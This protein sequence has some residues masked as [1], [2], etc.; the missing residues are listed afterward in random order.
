MSQALLPRQ[1][2]EIKAMEAA[3]Q[4]LTEGIERLQKQKEKGLTDEQMRKQ[5]ASGDSYST[6]GT[7]TNLR[8]LLHQKMEEYKSRVGDTSRLANESTSLFQSA[9]AADR[10]AVLASVPSLVGNFFGGVTLGRA[11]PH[12][13]TGNYGMAAWKGATGVPAAARDLILSLAGNKPSAKAWI[14]R[15]LNTALPLIGNMAAKMLEIERM[16]D[17]GRI[18]GVFPDEMSLAEQDRVAAATGL[19]HG[20]SPVLGPGEQQDEVRRRISQTLAR[21]KLGRF[22]AH[23]APEIVNSMEKETN[24]QAMTNGYDA[25]RRLFA[26]GYN[27]MDARSQSGVPG[28]DDFTNPKNVITAKE[29]DASAGWN[30][31][32]VAML[33]QMFERNGDLE[34][35]L[36]SYWKRRKAAGPDADVP[37]FENDG[38]LAE[39]LVHLSAISNL[40]L[41]ST[42]P[43]A[44]RGGGQLATTL[45]SLFSFMGWTS[46]AFGEISNAMGVVERDSRGATIG[47]AAVSGVLIL[48]LL[49]LT[50]MGAAEAR[51]VAYE[52]VNARPAP[53]PGLGTLARDPSLRTLGKVAGSSLAMN[54]PIVG[55]AI[56]DALGAPT[57]KQSITEFSSFSRPISVALNLAQGGSRVLKTG[58][59]AEFAHGA[60]QSLLPIGS[61][62]FNRLPGVD[63]RQAVADA[64]RVGRVAAG[65]LET[66][67]P[68]GGGLGAEPTR[69]SSLVKRAVARELAGDKE[70]ADALL[71]EAE[72]VKAEQSPG[73]NVRAAVRSS[74]ASKTP[75]RSAFGRK[76]SADEE[77]G[78][79]GRMSESQRQIYMRAKG[80]VKGLLERTKAPAKVKSGGGGGV[81]SRGR[82]SAAAGPVSA[83]AASKQRFQQR[84]PNLGS[85][86]R[87]TPLLGG[88]SSRARPIYGRGGTR[89]GSGGGSGSRLD[90]LIAADAALR[91]R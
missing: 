74:I 24:R 17:I 1:I 40:P 76:L 29:A 75:D 31:D 87:K 80:G 9:A 25:L 44:M 50:G 2:Q 88:T 26:S 64:A 3:I 63:A 42:R 15:N 78:L 19:V 30:P 12:L 90:R 81:A 84:Y 59:V 72:M 65:P 13:A 85:R 7:L 45:Q 34:R 27:L 49:M 16:T 91:Q 35:L 86:T 55:P 62:V 66:R 82:R 52:L 22:I 60:A 71:A 57:M 67:A 54:L 41:G 47:A 32:T 53:A 51:K 48:A 11:L 61:P 37:L 33:H 21:T 8:G 58:D 28:W 18:A 68:G 77:A 38:Q 69:F 39:A 43:D 83:Y 36:H 20:R 46:N 4:G 56:A 14:Q 89:D 10:A 5:V 70:G 6:V 79:L 23:V 73:S